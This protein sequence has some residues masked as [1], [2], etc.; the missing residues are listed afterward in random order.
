MS[1]TAESSSSSPRLPI[2]HWPSFSQQLVMR[3]DKQDLPFRAFLYSLGMFFNST[4]G[5]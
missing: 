3:R 2:V 5:S 4:T 1:D